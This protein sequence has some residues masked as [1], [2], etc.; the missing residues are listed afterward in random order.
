[1][2]KITEDVSVLFEHNLHSISQL[3]YFL[4]L[5]EF[6]KNASHC[7][8]VLEGVFVFA[9]KRRYI[10]EDGRPVNLVFKYGVCISGVISGEGRG[11][12]TA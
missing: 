7:V 2:T 5:C 9:L 12:A 10:F 3:S 6:Y 8:G 1:M 11:F 4:H